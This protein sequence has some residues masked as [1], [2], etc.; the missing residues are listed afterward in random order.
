MNKFKL[1]INGFALLGIVGLLSSCGGGGGGDE[2][3]I[4]PIVLNFVLA[5]F[6]TNGADW[7]DYVTGSSFANAN[8]TACDAAS[9][10]SCIHGGEVRMVEV[11]GRTSCAG[12]TA[13]DALGAFNWVCDASTSPVRMV[14]TGLADGKYLSNLID[15]TT[16]AFI[17]NSVTVF[18]NSAEFGNTPASEWWGNPLVI[19]NTGNSIDINVS[20]TISLVTANPSNNYDFFNDK[21]AL[22][23]Q[24]DVT[25]M[26]G[27]GF[28]V[29]NNNSGH[30]YFWIEGK[31]DASGEPVGIEAAQVRF[32]VARNLQVE[33]STGTGIYIN[34]AGETRMTDVIAS[35][36]GGVGIGLDNVEDGQFSNLT[37]NNNIEGI[38]LDQSHG[39]TFSN[40]VSNN[41]NNPNGDGIQL[42]QSENNTFENVNVDDNGHHGIDL[43]YSHNNQFSGVS[44]EGNGINGVWLSFSTDIQLTDVIASDNGESGFFASSTLDS[45]FTNLTASNNLH[46]GIYISDTSSGLKLQKIVT[47]NNGEYG[48]RL[49]GANHTLVDMITTNNARDIGVVGEEAGFSFSAVNS[50]IAMVSTSNNRAHGISMDGLGH[51]T[52]LGLS[53][54][55]HQGNG[56]YLRTDHNTLQA[57][58]VTHASFGIF[59]TGN[60]GNVFANTASAN[61]GAEGIRLL[62]IEDVKFTGLLEVG[63]NFFYDCYV[64]ILTGFDNPGLIHDTCAQNGASDHLLIGPVDLDGTG[65]G[66]LSPAFVGQVTSDDSQNF[67]DV[68]GGYIGFP[69]EPALF[70]WSNFENAFRGWGGPGLA[71]WENGYNGRIWDWSASSA[72]NGAFDAG[73]ASPPCPALLGVVEDAAGGILPDGDHTFTHVWSTASGDDAYCKTQVADSTWN[74]AVCVTVFLRDSMEIMSDSIGNDNSLCE[75]DET[76]LY[77]PNIG[78]YQGHGNLVSAG[79]FID[80]STGGLTGIT[81][82]R[83]ATN[84]R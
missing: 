23:I 13:T 6:D 76:C 72:D 69:L 2:E 35:N 54:G 75:S 10:P 55:N 47:I 51:S 84:G 73:C 64:T 49:E 50:R 43:S 70:D 74:G 48:M 5:L 59:L 8:D 81:L 40:L 71:L 61:N 18:L 52:L 14:S 22:V 62:T 56:L 39:N 53:S 11:T 37:V 30:N 32:L 15:F 44:A 1:L 12:L 46:N 80:S 25:M 21:L 58:A 77:M 26:S 33:N 65:P 36:N 27:S 7:N 17:E 67:S 28:G 66:N 20:G 24:P 3:V 45:H 60:T 38:S 9:S 78:S 57:V 42:Y 29:V 4:D 82:M 68:D 16:P 19:N 31:I 34:G 83:Y 41:N 79:T 63:D